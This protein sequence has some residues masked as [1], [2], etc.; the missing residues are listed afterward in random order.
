M[1]AYV[2]ALSVLQLGTG[3]SILLLADGNGE[4]TKVGLGD[5]GEWNNIVIIL[6]LAVLPSLGR[7]Q[8]SC[9]GMLLR[10]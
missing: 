10:P 8:S 3:N 1:F 5:Q 9:I 2:C 7:T 4:F 6:P